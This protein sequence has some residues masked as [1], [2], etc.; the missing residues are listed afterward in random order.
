MTD[1]ELIERVGNPL[2]RTFLQEHLD[3]FVEDVL[4]FTEQILAHAPPES[5]CSVKSSGLAFY[6]APIIGFMPDIPWQ[7]IKTAIANAVSGVFNAT[8]DGHGHPEK[9]GPSALDK[10][11]TEVKRIKQ[12]IIAAFASICES[13]ESAMGAILIGGLARLLGKY[14]ALCIAWALDEVIEHKSWPIV[15]IPSSD[16]AKTMRTE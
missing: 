3:E 9:Q 2:V 4:L 14:I 12:T 5:K 11:H 7:T 6:S 13:V 8:I 15:Q 1:A 10:N 16:P